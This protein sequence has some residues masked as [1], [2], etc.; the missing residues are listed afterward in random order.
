METRSNW[1]MVSLVVGLLISAAIGF[2]AWLTQARDAEGLTYE[3]HFEQSVDGLQKGSRVN[4]LGVPVGRLD[5]EGSELAPGASVYPEM[6][7]KLAN[8]FATCGT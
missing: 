8:A 4:L 1:L 5:P 2:A 3:I 6:M 7:R